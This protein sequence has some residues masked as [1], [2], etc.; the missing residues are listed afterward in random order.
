MS[1]SRTLNI[2]QLCAMFKALSNP[3]RLRIFL[4]LAESC[5]RAE[6]AATAEG[7]RCCVGELGE[8]L[9]VTPSTVSHHI[10]ELRQSGLMNVERCGQKIECWVSDEALSLLATFFGDAVSRRARPLAARRTS[11]AG[12][13]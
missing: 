6:C 4:K 3:Q 1:K 9:K 13:R 11:S 5:C 7:M 8:D 2:E 10:K 12:R